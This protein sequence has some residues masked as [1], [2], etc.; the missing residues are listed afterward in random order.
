MEAI[1]V[2]YDKQGRMNYHPEYHFAHGKPFEEKELEYLCKF[3][4][5]DGAANIS[6][7]LGR[8]ESTLREKVRALKI[9]DL[10]E[11]YKNLNKHW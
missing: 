1:E 11:H 4:E 7:A 5:S 10:F 9:N 3:Y 2:T 8:T 6:F